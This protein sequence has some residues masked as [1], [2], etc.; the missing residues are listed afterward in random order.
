MKVIE[1]NHDFVTIVTPIKTDV[2]FDLDLDNPPSTGPEV[3]TRQIVLRPGMLHGKRV[4][5]GYDSETDTLYVRY[6][7]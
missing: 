1:T 2:W 4:L 6:A 3:R 7:P 5:R